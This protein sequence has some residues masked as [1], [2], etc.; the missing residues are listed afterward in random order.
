M[1]RGTRTELDVQATAIRCELAKHLITCGAVVG[2][3]AFE[4]VGTFLVVVAGL[5]VVY[6]ARVATAIGRIMK[7]WRAS[8]T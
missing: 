2:L 8:H 4:P 3:A 1:M 7:A 5:C 6:S